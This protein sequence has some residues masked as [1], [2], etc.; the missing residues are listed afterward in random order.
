MET[1]KAT[2]QGNA[3]LEGAEFVWKYYDGY[4]TKKIIFH[5]NQ[6]AHGRQRQKRKKA[7]ITLSTISQDWQ[8]PI[9]YLVTALYTKGVIC[10]PLGTITVEEKICSNGYL[11]DGAYMQVAGS[12]EQIKRRVCADYRRWRTLSIKQSNQYSVSDKIIRGG[13][14]IQKRDLKQKDTKPQGG[15]TL[16]RYCL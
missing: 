16:K 1:G 4:Y 14:R 5:Q 2:A 10:L 3:S 11:F 8:I 15:A 13:V 12:S 7:A 9:R 6:H